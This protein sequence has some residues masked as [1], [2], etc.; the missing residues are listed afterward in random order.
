[1]RERKVEGYLKDQV[2]ASGGI[3]RKTRYIGRR[4]CP[5]RWCGWPATKK[6]GWVETKKPTTPEATAN[7]AREHAR[8]RSCGERVDVL[9]TIEEV[10]A[11]VQEMSGE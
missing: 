2:E 4:N 11:Y 5:D 8:L 7:Q 6:R 3:I 1:M 10:D 9:A